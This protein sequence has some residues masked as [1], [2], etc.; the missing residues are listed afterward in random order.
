MTTVSADRS[1]SASLGAR[2]PTACLL[3][4]SPET[5]VSDSL[6]PDEIAKAWSVVG[7]NLSASGRACMNGVARIEQHVCRVCGFQFFAP[8]VPGDSDF[9]RELQEQYPD[10]YPKTCPAFDRA[11]DF[12]RRRELK[13]VMDIGCGAGFF[14]DQARAAGLKTAGL[15][16]NAK[17]V[18]DCQARG[19]DV[20][21]NTMEDFAASN[22][23]E[24]FEFV[25]SFEVVEHVVDPA[26]FVRAAAALLRPGGWLGLAVPNNQGV[27]SLCELEPHQWP[28]HHLTRWRPQDLAQVGAVAGLRLVEA[29]SDVR[30]GWHIRYFMKLQG[31]IEHALGR[32]ASAPGN[33]WPEIACFVYRASLMKHWGPRQGLGLYAFFQ[34]PGP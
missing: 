1:S 31:Q 9:Y 4:G 20:R 23:A 22:P 15:D 19:H 18:A 14:L 2:Q 12:A 34:K 8:P 7:V 26:G 16:L 30:H 29:G 17:A 10:Y 27:H 32:R 28:P 3:C 6:T 13:Q 21:L 24:R 5:Q 33:L 11:V 25:T